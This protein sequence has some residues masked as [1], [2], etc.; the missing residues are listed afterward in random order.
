VESDTEK[1]GVSKGRAKPKGKEYQYC[2]GMPLGKRLEMGVGTY[3]PYFSS[4]DMIRLLFFPS[5]YARWVIVL[6]GIPEVLPS[7]VECEWVIECIVLLFSAV[8]GS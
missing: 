4:G 1:K 5:R 2:L 6:D 7:I 3:L 8:R